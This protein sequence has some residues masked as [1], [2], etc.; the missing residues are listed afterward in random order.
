MSIVDPKYDLATS[1]V[2]GPDPGSGMRKAFITTQPPTPS[3][4]KY[5]HGNLVFANVSLR[6][7]HT[8]KM[9]WVNNDFQGQKL[10]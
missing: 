9:E 2:V 7:R 6:A 1:L 3:R 8:D 5:L 10:L 4:Q